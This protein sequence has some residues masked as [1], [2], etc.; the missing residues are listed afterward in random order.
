MTVVKPTY[1]LLEY[2]LRNIFFKLTS[3]SHIVEQIAASCNFNDKE[4]VLL[5]LKVLVETHDVL[6]ASLLQNDHFL[7]YLA[8][9]RVF[10][11]VLLVDALYRHHVLGQIMQGE[12]YLAEGAFTENLAN[13]VKVYSG[14][15]YLA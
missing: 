2:T 5:G 6:V 14:L 3:F 8:T 9:L 1:Q 12:V 7:E 10:T 11:K 15:R 4:D 13:S